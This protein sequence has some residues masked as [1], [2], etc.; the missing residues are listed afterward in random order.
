MVD[1]FN[2]HRNNQLPKIQKQPNK[3]TLEHL[4]TRIK[5]LYNEDELSY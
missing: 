4:Q 5:Q 2:K 3:H 1:V